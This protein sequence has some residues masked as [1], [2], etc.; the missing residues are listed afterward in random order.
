MTSHQ[1]CSEV[2]FLALR[3]YLLRPGQCSWRM[4]PHLQFAFSNVCSGVSEPFTAFMEIV[5][6]YG[7]KESH[8]W[9][10]GTCSFHPVENVK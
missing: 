2:S 1:C 8:L 4:V 6:G 9:N 7:Y 10:E 3:P 5:D